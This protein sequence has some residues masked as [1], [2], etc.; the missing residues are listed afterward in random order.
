MTGDQLSISVSNTWVGVGAIHSTVFCS[1]LKW[2]VAFLLFCS[3]SLVS[4]GFF[5][6]KIVG[7]W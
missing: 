6:F 1:S 7:K 3:G 5:F 2:Y 4:V